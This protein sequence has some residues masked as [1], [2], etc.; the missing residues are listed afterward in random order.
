MQLFYRGGSSAQPTYHG[1]AGTRWKA[2]TATHSSIE[3]CGGE[4]DNDEAEGGDEDDDGDKDEHRSGGEDEKDEDDGD[5]QIEEPK[6][7]AARRNHARTYQP[8]SYSTHSGR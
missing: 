1:V 2:R 8:P 7:L 3:K 5:D 6:P 4:N